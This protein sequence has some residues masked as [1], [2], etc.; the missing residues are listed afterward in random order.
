MIGRISCLLLLSLTAVTTIQAQL[1]QWWKDVHHYDGTSDWNTYMT[2]TPA[3]FG[4]NALPVPE[5]S[6]GRIATKHTAELSADFFWG[7]GD[8][9]QS[10]STRL[11]YVFI[12]GRLAV[13]GWGVLAEHYR[14]TTA[15]R[16]QRASQVEDA[17]ETFLMGDFY[18]STQIG[19]LKEG[20]YNPDLMLDIILKTASSKTAS[21]ARYFDTPG[22][23]FNLTAGKSLSSPES[24]V[25]EIRFAA[26]IGFLCYQMNGHFQNDAPVY[27]G[28][29]RLF[30]GNWFWE[31]GFGG[32][33]GWTADGDRPFVLRSKLNYRK[34]SVHYF[35]QYQHALRDYPFRRLQTGVSFEF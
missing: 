34:N 20:S 13:T 27:G 6:D 17:E 1:P 14:T 24:F 8:Q 22:Y 25:Q 3:N 35:V 21:N 7:Y 2:Y 31:N 23:C 26:N 4:P 28:N 15:V 19:L 18:L 5:L 33:N 10:F 32:Y 11:T 16:D 9:T 12:P 30:S 29:V